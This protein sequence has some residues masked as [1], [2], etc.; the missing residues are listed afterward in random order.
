MAFL[1]DHNEAR[2]LLSLIAGEGRM[3]FQTVQENGGQK[4]A[5]LNRV[6][7]G[8]FEQMRVRLD[9]LNHDGAGVFF[10]V[11]EGD[12]EGRKA[13]NVLRIR[14]VFADLDGAPLQ[15]VLDGA[16]RPHAIVETSPGKFHVYW[17][18]DGLPIDSF[19]P[20]QQAIARRFHGDKK[21][22]D[23]NRVARLPGFQ[24]RKG[25]DP[26]LSRLVDTWD[27]APY[28]ATA[29]TAEFPVTVSMS[30][31]LPAVGTKPAT[32]FRLG[33]RIAEGE[34]NSRLYGIARK[35][36][37]TGK[38]QAEAN[39]RLQKVNAKQCDPPLCASEVDAIVSSAY[40]KPAD[41]KPRTPL[42]LMRSP[43]VRSL[44]NGAFRLLQHAIYQ[45]AIV[46]NGEIEIDPSDFAECMSLK[47]G[48]KYRRELV[49]SG[50]IQVTR[51]STYNEAGR[52]CA[53]FRVVGLPHDWGPSG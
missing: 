4:R 46:P 40:E 33:G 37:N 13:S 36:V 42:E 53:L 44:S 39:H 47:H 26:F 6:L 18:V 24:H 15:P 1:T 49:S 41:G 9:S 21:V 34:R 50:L 17:R 29:I 28:S 25:K 45:A 16:L 51:D 3:T 35:M 52:E 10:M 19:K 48:Y 7:H 38:A 5:G 14:A 2:R 8:T 12:C 30:A 20:V 31:P 27:G 43:L 23:P 11:N 22:S 32:R